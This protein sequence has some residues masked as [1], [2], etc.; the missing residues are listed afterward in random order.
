MDKMSKAL[1]QAALIITGPMRST[2]IQELETITG[3]Q[4]LLDR[5]HEKLLTQ[6]AKFKR[7]SGHPMEK[8][9]YQPTRGRLKRENF[10]HQSRCLEQRH[11]DILE[12]NP[13]KISQCPEIPAWSKERHF[14]VKSGLPGIGPKDS[15]NDLMRKLIILE[16]LQQCYPKET[17][18]YIFTDGSAEDTTCNGGAGV[19]VK[20]PDG[21]DDRLSFAT[22]LYSTN[23]KAETEALKVVA[24]HIENSPHLSHRVVFLSDALSLL[25]ALQTGKDTDLNNLVSNLTRFCMKH[26][27]ILRWIPSQCGIHG[28]EAADT[29]AKEGTTY[30]QNDRSTTYSEVKTIIKAKQQNLFKNRPQSTRKSPVPQAKNR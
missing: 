11:R 6:A 10:V 25:Q 17:W 23:Y 24:A 30:A 29:L 20:Y 22:G 5:C 28:N 9:M 18:T 16:H 4:P 14:L 2:P 26:T 27:V 19:Y 21:T 7:L 8:R 1:N 15:Q 13:L 3:L 12:Q